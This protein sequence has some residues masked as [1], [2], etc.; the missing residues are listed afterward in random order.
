MYVGPIYRRQKLELRKPSPLVGKNLPRDV[1]PIIGIDPGG[2]TGLSLLVLKKN[3]FSRDVFSFRFD[4]IL[5]QKVMWEHSEINC[6]NFENEATYIIGALFDSWPSAVIVCEDF[7]LRPNRNERGRDLLS[8]VRMNAKLEW[9]L[10]TK[11]R[12]MHFQSPS[13]AKTAITDE[14]MKL[15]N[16]YSRDG[17]LIHARDAD[18]HVLLF[19]RR[20]IQTPGL[21]K[22]AWPS[23]YLDVD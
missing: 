2:T 20:C 4:T 18:R 12:R 11:G 19:I 7:I 21:R 10:W 9:Y 5:G 14:R 6:F 23:C 13:A 8:P 1:L 17:G 22:I 16:C 3:I 15:W